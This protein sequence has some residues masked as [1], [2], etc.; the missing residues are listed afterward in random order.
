M[1]NVVTL[2][3]EQLEF[4][5]GYSSSPGVNYEN[6]RFVFKKEGISLGGLIFDDMD[7]RFFIDTDLNTNA[8][9]AAASHFGLERNLEISRL[10][11][12]GGKTR[13]SF[14][15][16]DL[17]NFCK[18]LDFYIHIMKRQELPRGQEKD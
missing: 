15:E 17:L 7:S 4:M 16:M 12:Y 14:N 9:Y 1:N 6:L 2:M 5:V 18:V 8:F 13:V 3:K 11:Q 10:D